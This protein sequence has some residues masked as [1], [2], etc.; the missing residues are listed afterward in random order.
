VTRFLAI[1]VVLLSAVALAQLES[2]LLPDS[3]PKLQPAQEA[4][5]RS[6]GSTLRCPVCRGLPIAESPAEL[7]RQMMGEL[8]TQIAAGKNDDQIVDYFIARYGNSV[9]LSP[10]KSGVGLIVWLAPVL[11]VLLGGWGLWTFL[12]GSSRREMPEADPALLARVRAELAGG[13]APAPAAP[14]AT[15]PRKPAKGAKK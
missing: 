3:G 7:A 4:R 14:I 15:E 1:I 13:P 12:R 10:P 8:R 6:I 9:L 2:P 11:A 5:A